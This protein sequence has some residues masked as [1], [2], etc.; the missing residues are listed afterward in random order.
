[1]GTEPDTACRTDLE[2]ELHYALAIAGPSRQQTA[3]SASN[4]GQPISVPAMKR[5]T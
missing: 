5:Q 1:M 4:V 3:L 2:P